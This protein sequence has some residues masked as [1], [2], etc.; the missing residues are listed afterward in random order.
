AKYAFIAELA[1]AFAYA[2]T[3]GDEEW[4]RSSLRPEVRGHVWIGGA[5]RMWRMPVNDAH[6]NPIFLDIR[7]WVP[8]GD[9]FDVAPNNPLPIP[10]WLHMGGPLMIAG[11]IFLNRSAFTGQDIVNPAIDNLGDKTKKYGEFLWR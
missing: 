3:D 8:A 6:G 7:R 4:E 1:N 9:I 10:A 5:P 2:V 11:E